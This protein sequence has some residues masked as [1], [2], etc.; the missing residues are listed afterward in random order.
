MKNFE[1]SAKLTLIK[2]IHTAVW[3]MMALAVLY[4]LF[5]GIFDRVT[6][7]IWYCIGLIFVEGLVACVN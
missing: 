1:D 7:L 3:S 4:V 2:L 5:A 6:V